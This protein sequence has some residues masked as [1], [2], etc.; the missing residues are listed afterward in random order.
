MRP[1]PLSQTQNS[2][3]R[4][5]I[6]ALDA[7]N[8]ALAGLPWQPLAGGRSN[9][10]W[11]VGK[12]VVKLY[13]A[14][15][16]SPLF[17]NDSVAE[18]RALRL[19][20]PYGLA[21]TL[22]ATGAGWLAYDHA[23]GSVWSGDPAPVAH[24][25]AR[26][27]RLPIATADFRP[28]PSGSRALHDQA[29]Q[30]AADCAGVL[31]PPPPDAA[32]APLAQPKLIHGDAVPGN[33]ICHPQGITLIDWQCP[34]IGDPTEDLAAFLSPA[35]QWL[36]RGAPLS[37]DQAAAFLNAYPDPALVARYH[38][39]APAFHWRMA[40]HCLWKAE[41]GAA[42]YATALQLELAAL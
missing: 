6:A 25:L 9:R 37:A 21:P 28:A 34:A 23:A 16:A 20:A 18:A 39:L 7:C 2:A 3:P 15:A 24:T 30:I 35:M 22:R 41:R 19:V 13:D 10:L 12:W 17:P 27:H 33:V 38:A 31:P 1:D 5:L 14:Q 4:A 32:I 42:D 40:A 11:Q 26:L 8:P 36:Y 29:A